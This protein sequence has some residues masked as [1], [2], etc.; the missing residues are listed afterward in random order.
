MTEPKINIGKDSVAIGQVTGNIGDESVVIGATDSNGNTILNQS[1]AVGYNAHASP[2][3]IAI[4]ANA[5]AGTIAS[6]NSS[7]K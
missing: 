7:K 6:T 3:S 2:G 1:I 5:G 4:G